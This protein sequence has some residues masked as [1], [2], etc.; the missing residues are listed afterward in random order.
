LDIL[1]LASAFEFAIRLGEDCEVAAG[2][3]IGA[4]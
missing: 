1:I 4:E 2:E 3:V